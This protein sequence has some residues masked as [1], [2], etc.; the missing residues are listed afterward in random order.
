MG[1]PIV[2]KTLKIKVL[3]SVSIESYAH[4]AQLQ[5]PWIQILI[6]HSSIP[7]WNVLWFKYIR[8]IS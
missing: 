4:T 8:L 2:H 5:D 6:N 1:F 3:I 7:T